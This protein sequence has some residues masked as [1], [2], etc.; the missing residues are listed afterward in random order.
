MIELTLPY[1]PS[2]N[3]YYR[4][5]RSRNIL[6]SEARQYKKL[7]AQIL[8]E[9]KYVTLNGTL[10]CDIELYPPDNRKHDTDNR[11]KPLLDSLEKAK[12]YENDNQI[13]KITI[14]MYQPDKSTYP[15]GA[16][17]VRVWERE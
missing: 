14:E 9:E 1:P 4:C 11:I 12:V 2:V 17:I 7:V 3:Q 5:V 15:H 6:S 16:T 13:K 10:E 8:A